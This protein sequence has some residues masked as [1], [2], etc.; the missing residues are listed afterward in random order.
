MDL[1]TTLLENPFSLL[2]GLFAIA[3]AM[4][5]II[6]LINWM[7]MQEI[8]AISGILGIVIAA[9]LCAIAIKP[10]TP[11]AGPLAF[12]ALLT[13][14]IMVPILR[15]ILNKRQLIMVDVEVI[16]RGYEALVEKPDNF[17]AKLRIARA[18]YATG[19]H[20]AAYSILDKLLA[21][22]SPSTFGEELR[23]LRQWREK[24]TSAD[25]QKLRCL[26]C[27]TANP[28]DELYC[29]KCGR[30]YLRDHA[31]GMWVASTMVRKL[32]AVWIATTASIFGIPIVA[33]AL[34]P[35][36]SL[37]AIPLLLVLAVFAIWYGFRTKKE[38]VG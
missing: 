7:I 22:A 26:E 13:I 14:V 12:L 15:N 29:T 17:S 36:S 27:G 25:A 37:V 31:M 20:G 10:P 1:R 11:A 34:D 38:P 16:D 30:R 6:S 23:M 8:D 2:L 21:G 35:T 4:V 18:L 24:L 32:V 9:I 5:W 28:L 19:V 3:P 33:Q